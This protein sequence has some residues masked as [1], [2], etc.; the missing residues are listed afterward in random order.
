MLDKTSSNPDSKVFLQELPTLLETIDAIHHSIRN[1]EASIVKQLITNKR[2][3]LARDK[4]GCTPLHTAIIYE[5]TEIVRFIAAH[6][7]MVLNAPDY[8]SSKKLQDFLFE[9]EFYRI[10]ERQCIM[11]LRQKMVDI[12]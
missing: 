1:G 4:H 7:P 2:L 12:I 6:F 10:R 5:E 11:L 9:L 3:A 8:V